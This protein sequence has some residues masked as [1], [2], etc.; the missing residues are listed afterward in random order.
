[1]INNNNSYSITK[2]VMKRHLHDERSRLFMK[3]HPSMRVYKHA[4]FLIVIILF[5]S[6]ILIHLLFNIL[7]IV[8]MDIFIFQVFWIFT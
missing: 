8:L 5:I 7:F 6:F 4:I 2:Y 1:M 3:W